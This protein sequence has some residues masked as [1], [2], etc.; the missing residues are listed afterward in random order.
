VIL[1]SGY[2]YQHPEDVAWSNLRTFAGA[3]DC[4]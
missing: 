4:Q 3:P 2:G 1:G